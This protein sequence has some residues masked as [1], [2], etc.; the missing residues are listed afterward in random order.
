[1]ADGSIDVKKLKR[2]N[3]AIVILFLLYFP[4]QAYPMVLSIILNSGSS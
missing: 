4:L 2:L 1:M 3:G